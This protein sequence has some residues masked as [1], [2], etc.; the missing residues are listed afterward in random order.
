MTRVGF[1]K[2]GTL[3]YQ[4]GFARVHGKNDVKWDIYLGVTSFTVFSFQHYN[5]SYSGHEQL[6]VRMTNHITDVVYP[7]MVFR[8][9]LLF[10]YLF[11]HIYT[12]NA[13]NIKDSNINITL[14][15]VLTVVIHIVVC[16]QKVQV[17]RLTVT[18]FT[19]LP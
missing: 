13:H 12:L 7:Y 11:L 18:R 4:R 15:L 17:N 14:S 5:R 9:L 1:S 3:R 16:T 8:Y 10:R 6:D 19:C 2:A